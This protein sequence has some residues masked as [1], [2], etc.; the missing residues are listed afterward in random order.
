MFG[1]G[2]GEFFTCK[3]KQRASQLGSRA[4]WESAGVW[5]VGNRMGAF[6]SRERE[7]DGAE[8]SNEAGSKTEV[9]F[10]KYK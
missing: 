2:T 6:G 1:Q 7:E 3:W 8:I 9:L 10:T 5:R 4:A